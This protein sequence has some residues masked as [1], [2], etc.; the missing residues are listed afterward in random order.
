MRCGTKRIICVVLSI[1]A[2]PI[3]GTSYGFNGLN[4]SEFSFSG[5]QIFPFTSGNVDYLT[6]YRLYKPSFRRWLWVK[7][8]IA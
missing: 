8:L 6:K 4:T 2:L 1:V 3:V 7:L 5:M